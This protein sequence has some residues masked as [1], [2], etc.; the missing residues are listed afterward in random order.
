MNKVVVLLAFLLT[1]FV[2][3]SQNYPENSDVLWVTTPSNTNWIYKVGEQAKITVALY[4]YGVLQSNINIKYSIGPELMK[5][6]KEG[7]ITLQ[8]CKSE[9]TLGTLN[10]PGFLDCRLKAEINGK[11]YSH[12]IKVGF[13]PEKLKPYT[14]FPSDF[15]A[16]WDKAKAEAALC[17]MVVEKTFAPE[18]SSDKV[19]CYLVK[20]QAFK[21]G[22][23][24]Y[25][26]LSIP[27]KEGKFPA[28]FSP[29]GAGIKPMDPVKHMFYAESGVIRFDMEIH[30][31]RPDLDT[32]TYKE[33]SR[34]F[35]GGNNAYLINGIEDRDRYYLKKVYLSCIRAIDY[36]VSLPQ[37]DGKNLIAQ[38]GSQGGALAL[39]TTA[40]DSRITACAAAHPALSDMAGYLDN[41][42]GGYPHMYT[43]YKGIDK[44][45]IVKTLQYYDVVN[46]AK[47]INVPV[48]MTWGFND[49]VCPPTTSYIVYNSIKANKKALI[50][51]VNEHWVS[52]NTRRVI[53]DWIKTQFK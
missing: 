35:G 4:H 28:V 29:P 27:K 38:G 32:K 17:P 43:E 36:I 26:Y 51:P 3:K 20:I 12:H 7:S 1:S 31:I 13:D 37:W 44:P 24:V 48:F 10:K 16:F 50:T 39:T 6:E 52:E 9:L 15:T 14:Q 49:N 47:V 22:Y 33:I 42:A 19:D 8:N 23:G 40:L 46:F 25:G 11:T 5:T 53:L 30:G 2:A 34:S 21:E 45:E 41:R 18:Y